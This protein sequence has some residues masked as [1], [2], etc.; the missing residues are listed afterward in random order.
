MQNIINSR[1]DLDLVSNTPAYTAFMAML[2]GS[3]WRLEKDDQ[4]GAWVAVEDNSTIER[5]GFTRAD[6][7]GANPP[8][9]PAY[10]A[11]AVVVPAA[12]SRRQG[13]LALIDAGLL[14]QVEAYIGSLEDPRDRRIAQV[15]YDADTWER[16]NPFLCQ[17]W[18]ALGKSESELDALFV[19]AAGL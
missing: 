5:F 3:L 17:L 19:M 13:R 7:P 4:A 12:V 6:F 8:P 18:S 9:L 1:E 16:F 2:A 14:D 11:P 10:E 15:E